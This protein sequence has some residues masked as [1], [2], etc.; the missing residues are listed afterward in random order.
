MSRKLGDIAGQR[1]HGLDVQEFAG[2]DGEPCLQLNTYSGGYAQLD[3]DQAEQLFELLGEWLE[4]QDDAA[5]DDD[6]DDSD[7][8]DAEDPKP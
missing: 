8:D 1:A 6:G 7:G 2:R 4:R 5:D 3:V